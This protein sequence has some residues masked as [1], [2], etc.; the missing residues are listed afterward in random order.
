MTL[1]YRAT[2]P[3]YCPIS[4]W[5]TYVPEGSIIRCDCGD[6]WLRKNS[7]PPMSAGVDRWKRVG[8]FDRKARRIIKQWEQGQ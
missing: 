6:Y 5:D 4:T 2:K 3:H 1:I 8:P 7:Y